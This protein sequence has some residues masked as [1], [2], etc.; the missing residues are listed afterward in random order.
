MSGPPP[1]TSPTAGLCC[2]ACG[3][4]AG[5]CGSGGGVALRQTHPASGGP[6]VGG[7]FSR[8]SPPQPAALLQRN[9]LPVPGESQVLVP[10]PAPESY[11]QISSLLAN[12]VS[13]K[14]PHH[15]YRWCGSYL[16]RRATLHIF[17]CRVAHLYAS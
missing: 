15:I 9:W 17:Q 6:I 7:A 16:N 8:S 3:A 11:H 5:S 14:P 1:P 12:S 13:H 4:L 10:D 2:S